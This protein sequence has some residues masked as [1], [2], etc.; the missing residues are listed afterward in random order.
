MSRKAPSRVT[1]KSV[2]G[3][4]KPAAKGRKAK[5]ESQEKAKGEWERFPKPD[6]R[7]VALAINMRFGN[8]GPIIRP[9]SEAWNA[10]DLRRPNGITSI[11]LSTGGGLPAGGVCQVDGPESTGKNYLLYRYFAEVQRN[12]GER[13]CVAM[14]CFENFVDKHFAQ[15]CGVRVQMSKYDIDV[16]QRARKLRGEEPLTKQ[17]IKEA[18]ECPG[19]GEF[20]IFEGPAENV[21]D[22]IVY[23]VEH[24]IYQAIGI[25]S[26]DMML[27]APEDTAALDETPQVASPAMLQTKWS[28]KILDALNPIFRCP[29]CARAPLDKHVTDTKTINFKYLCPDC[30][31]KG[32]DPHVEVNE[33][34]IVAI[35]QSRAKLN[36][37]GGKTYGRAY[38]SKGAYALQHV[39][40]IRL[41]LYPGAPIRL[42][43]VKIGKEVNWEVT[44][45][46]SGTH[47]GASGTFSLYFDPLEVDTDGD[48]L[49]QCLK[50]KVIE[51]KDGARYVIPEIEMDPVH[52]EEKMLGLLETEPELV[53]TLKELLYVHAGLAHVRL[54]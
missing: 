30:G 26:W 10:F 38:D 44:K 7:Q 8:N 54:V 18:I 51:K 35:R 45:G 46:K 32:L 48:L 1:A 14:A 20:H 16:T 5:A 27:T 13:A 42:K 25:D 23:A 9:A 4:D 40:L 28:K 33:T 11:D 3:E 50:H 21:L 36:L 31:W 49:T 29:G 43:D 37:G 19:V 34:T 17:E 12:Y 6:P 39:N 15:M 53:R 22:G 2:G 47:E 41:S 52:G 24:N